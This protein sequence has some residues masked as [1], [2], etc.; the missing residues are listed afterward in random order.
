MIQS[1]K[2]ICN[3]LQHITTHYNTLPHIFQLPFWKLLSLHHRKVDIH[4]ILSWVYN[5][6][7]SN[8][9]QFFGMDPVS[10]ENCTLTPL[11]Y[12]G[13]IEEETTLRVPWQSPN[14]TIKSLY[15]SIRF[16]KF[17]IV[18][19]KWF[20]LPTFLC[21]FWTRSILYN[22][23]S[24]SI[25]K[26]RA[27]TIAQLGQNERESNNRWRQNNCIIGSVSHWN[28]YL[29]EYIHLRKCEQ[30]VLEGECHL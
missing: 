10:V 28:Y 14:S 21:Y 19:S 29:K 18:L 23:L 2:S 6:F 25:L 27:S 15:Y 7:V 5:V 3:R 26:S 9:S 20:N 8:S 24:T 11:K 1:F 12:L 22:L 13:K 16:T 30:L 4:F 17:V